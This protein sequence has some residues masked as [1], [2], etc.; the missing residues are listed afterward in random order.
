M[1]DSISKTYVTTCDNE[2]KEYIKVTNGNVIMTSAAHEAT[3][4]TARQ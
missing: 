2:I 3:D 4:R 1:C